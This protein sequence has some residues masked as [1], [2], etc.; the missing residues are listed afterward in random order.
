MARDLSELA[1]ELSLQRVQQQDQSLTE[2]R[3]RNG[4]LLA[5]SS[6][7]I[8]VLGRPAFDAN[9]V[10]GGLAALAFAGSIV[11]SLYVLMPKRNLVFSLIGSRVYEE[12]YEFKDDISEVQ[13][14]LAYDLD[15]FWVSNDRILRKTFFAFR[16]ATWALG[17]EVLLLLA[18]AG[19]ILD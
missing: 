14:R 1:Y 9:A 3:A 4:L 13:R 8:S 15:R 19:G 5:S 6:L 16:V 2:I 10:I 18:T 12:L 17:I 11:A 7:T